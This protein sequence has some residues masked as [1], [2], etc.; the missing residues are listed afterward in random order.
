[1]KTLIIEIKNSNLSK[2]ELISLYGVSRSAIYLI[3]HSRS[4]KYLNKE[5]EQS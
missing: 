2:K 1:M 4:W 5:N 3:Q